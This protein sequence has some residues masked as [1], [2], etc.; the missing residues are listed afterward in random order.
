MPKLWN[1]WFGLWVSGFRK[2]EL[3]F[4]LT[5]SLVQYIFLQ[6]ERS[7][8]GNADLICLDLSHTT[9]ADLSDLE[10]REKRAAQRMSRIVDACESLKSPN[11]MPPPW[12]S[13]TWANL[14]LYMM[15]VRLYTN[16]ASVPMQGCCIF[17][18]AILLFIL[19]PSYI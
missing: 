2:S 11:Y 6:L 16:F 10:K 8:H 14:G 19:S 12:A 4:Q 7:L 15:K 18:M 13:Y 9:D 5:F 17:N 1:L 3:L